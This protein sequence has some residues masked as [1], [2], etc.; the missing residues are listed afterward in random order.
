M[1]AGLCVCV[2]GFAGLTVM[3]ARRAAV[4]GRCSYSG[5]LGI[6]IGATMPSVLM[7]VQNA[8]ERRDVGAATGSLLFLRSMGGAFGSTIVGS[9]LSPTFNDGLARAGLPR[10]IWARCGAAGAAW[11]VSARRG[12]RW[13]QGSSSPSSSV[14]VLLLVA[15]VIA[16]GMKDLQ[17]R[18]ATDAPCGTSGT[19]GSA[20]SSSARPQRSP[21]CSPPHAAPPSATARPRPG[22]PAPPPPQSAAA[23]GPDR[24][25]PINH[26]ALAPL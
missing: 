6:G 20:R 17:L 16:L 26:L 25:R 3:T 13:P 11:P 23:A 5:V 21:G 15:V 22:A 7:Q 24:R 9:V 12:R 19:S 14:S 1:L 8:A 2:A 18:S 4:P 10:S